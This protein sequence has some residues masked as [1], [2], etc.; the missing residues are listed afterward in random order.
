MVDYFKKEEGRLWKGE[1]HFIFGKTTRVFLDNFYTFILI[2]A[3]FCIALKQLHKNC[4]I[5]LK[6]W[7]FLES[8]ESF[9]FKKKKI[10][11]Y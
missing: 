1:I 6:K 10:N 3:L 2:Q 7:T 11:N 9:F 5:A 4:K 8:C